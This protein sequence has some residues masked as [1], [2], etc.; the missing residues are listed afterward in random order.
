MHG[1]GSVELLISENCFLIFFF[2]TFLLKLMGVCRSLFFFLLNFRLKYTSF[3]TIIRHTLH[4]VVL[5]AFL[6]IIKIMFF[7]TFIV[8]FLIF[9][10][11]CKNLTIKKTSMRDKTHIYIYPRHLNYRIFVCRS[12][13]HEMLVCVL[14]VV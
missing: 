13:T 6:Y 2:K 12:H 3:I 1:F 10:E 5:N 8:K 4:N 14:V 11:F 9:Q 7:L